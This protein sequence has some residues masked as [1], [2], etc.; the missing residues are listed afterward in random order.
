MLPLLVAIF[1]PIRVEPA[2]L[3]VKLFSGVVPPKV[4]PSVVVPSA[5]RMSSWAPS[6]VPPRVMPPLPASRVA[7][8]ARV[9]SSLMTMSLLLMVT[10][11]LML[12]VPPELVV[13]PCRGVVAP[14]A[15]F[16][17]VAPVEL[18]VRLCPPSTVPTKVIAPVPA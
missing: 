18:R 4:L 2:A 15:A 9:R 10:L 14:I 8:L 3:V 5:L 7:L 12:E 11:P 1:P 13:N 17:V 6:T 16:R